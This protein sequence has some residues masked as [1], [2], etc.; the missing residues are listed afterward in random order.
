MAEAFTVKRFPKLSSCGCVGATRGR[1][2]GG[3]LIEVATAMRLFKVL[4]ARLSAISARRR[5]SL[6]LGVHSGS[7]AV[8]LVLGGRMQGGKWLH[9]PYIHV[10]HHSRSVL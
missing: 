1:H 6:S 8:E 9:S 4:P 3:L 10:P 2:Q 7:S 5:A